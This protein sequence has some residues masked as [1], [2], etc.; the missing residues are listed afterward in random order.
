MRC[1]QTLPQALHP[2][3]M[4]CSDRDF[5]DTTLEQSVSHFLWRSA[6]CTCPET[7]QHF[8]RVVPYYQQM[9]GTTSVQGVER[10]HR[11]APMWCTAWQVFRGSLD[12]DENRHGDGG[13]ISTNGLPS[14]SNA[15]GLEKF[16]DKTEWWLVEATL[17]RVG[18]P[19]R[20]VR[21][22]ESLGATRSCSVVTVHGVSRAFTPQSGLG[23]GCPLAALQAIPSRQPL[24]FTLEVVCQGIHIWSLGDAR[25]RGYSWSPHHARWEG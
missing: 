23:Q 21:S 18:V 9:T 22:V 12:H 5:R 17:V 6:R 8:T 25:P 11:Q 4:F 14:T 16:F 15:L 13:T 20:V 7:Y 24:A 10:V 1:E 19:L 3:E 2:L